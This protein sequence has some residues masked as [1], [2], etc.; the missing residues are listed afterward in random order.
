MLFNRLMLAMKRVVFPCIPGMYYT[1]GT[2][3]APYSMDGVNQKVTVSTNSLNGS[4][5]GYAELNGSFDFSSGKT[6]FEF[7]SRFDVMSG[8]TPGIDKI[9]LT[10]FV[11][12]SGVTYAMIEVTHWEDGKYRL[13][14][15][16]KS[17][18]FPAMYNT[19]NVTS[20]PLRVTMIFDAATGLFSIKG[21]GSTLTLGGDNS[22]S[23]AS[24]YTIYAHISYYGING[25]RTADGQIITAKD[26]MLYG[27]GK[28]L[29]GEAL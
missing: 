4:M 18:S 14:I 20:I 11:Y 27:E 22:F 6:S 13:L 7:K 28:T 3:S 1:A 5:G 10:Y 2:L 19:G 8:G 15:F 12:R 24:G 29:C 17:L 9:I 25:A 23:A 16:D 26:D 21:D